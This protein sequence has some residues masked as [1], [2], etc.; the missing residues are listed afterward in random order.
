[1][2][3]TG[4]ALEIAKLFMGSVF[5]QKQFRAVNTP[6]LL[7]KAN[8]E[9][10]GLIIQHTS[11]VATRIFFGPTDPDDNNLNETLQVDGDL[12][13]GEFFMQYGEGTWQGEVWGT[14]AAAD[15]ITVGEWNA[16][17]GYQAS[18]KELRD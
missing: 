3:R 10:I 7:L 18:R 16:V 2:S 6:F 13:F 15:F 5:K 9:R 8:P 17:H 12:D 11:G 1:M 4:K 14:A